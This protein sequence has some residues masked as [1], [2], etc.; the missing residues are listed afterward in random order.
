MRKK[1]ERKARTMWQTALCAAGVGLA[2]AITLAA[3][4]AALVLGGIVQQ[5]Q[6]EGAAVFAA[7]IGALAG[8]FY[9][10]KMAEQKKLAAA[11]LGAAVYA[12][13][14]LCLPRRGSACEP[15]R[16]TPPEATARCKAKVTANLH[17]ETAG[18]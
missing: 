7:G 8:A 6:I 1:S 3:L 15:D 11:A 14:L 16:C 12:F 2:A 4:F 18:K 13:V 9:A 17:T 10:V 5:R